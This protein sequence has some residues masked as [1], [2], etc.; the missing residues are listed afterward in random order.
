MSLNNVAL[1]QDRESPE[2]SKSAKERSSIAFPYVDLHDAISVAKAI[3]EKAGDSATISHLAT[4]LSHDSINSGA[5]RMKLY[6][7]RIFGLIKI[8]KNHAVLTTLGRQIADPSSE[9]VAKAKAFLNV[10]LYKSTFE[11]YDGYQLPSD[12]GLESVFVNLGVSDKQ[13]TRARQ[14]FQRSAKQAGFFEYGKDRLVA[15]VFAKDGA[16]TA[17]TPPIAKIEESPAE[18]IV[19]PSSKHPLIA[20]LFETVPDEGVAWD[21]T[22]RDKW[23][24]TAKS[25]F[26]L[27]YG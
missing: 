4:W 25:I 5:F 21:G 18:K 19:P 14:I 16:S 6:G 11:K 27:I 24:E 26:D 7:A 13:K 17:T 8:E 20:A 12:S 3:H 10:P 1:E 2:A 15:P 9:K 22:S 23:L